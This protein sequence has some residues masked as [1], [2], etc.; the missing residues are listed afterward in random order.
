MLLHLLTAAFG[1]TR[2]VDKVEI[3]SADWGEAEAFGGGS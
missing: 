3:R 1:T 2:P